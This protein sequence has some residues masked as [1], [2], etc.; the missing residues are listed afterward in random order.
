MVLI[1]SGVYF[2][3]TYMIFKTRGK[4][5]MKGKRKEGEKRK[6]ERKKAIKGR[7]MTKSDN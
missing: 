2:H 6:K 5:I 1:C 3:F 4:N 7:I